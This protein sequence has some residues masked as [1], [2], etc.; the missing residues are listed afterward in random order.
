MKVG[1]WFAIIIL[2]L[3]FIIFL[4]HRNTSAIEAI[5]K[6]SARHDS[7]RHDSAR[8]KSASPRSAATT[9]AAHIAPAH[10]AAHVATKTKMTNSP[11][12]DVIMPTKVSHAMVHEA[13]PHLTYNQI[14]KTLSGV[15][16]FTNQK[17]V[18]TLTDIQKSPASKKTKENLNIVLEQFGGLLNFITMNA[19][20]I[21]GIDKT[22]IKESYVVE[23]ITMV[24]MILPQVQ[25]L[26]TELAT[27]TANFA[28][29][30][31][32]KPFV[33]NGQNINKLY[34]GLLDLAYKF[35]NFV[36]I[37]IVIANEGIPYQETNVI[38]YTY[39]GNK[40]IPFTTENYF[41][42]IRKSYRDLHMSKYFPDDGSMISMLSALTVLLNKI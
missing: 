12:V 9:S 28:L 19:S 27:T 20:D 13:E 41:S 31:S 25:V 16:K 10:V 7:A 11:M 42:S 34:Y 3:L 15:P 38:T 36:N 35:N 24:E 8:H 23:A 21:T 40:K 2:I 33:D 26:N 18:I 14:I 39:N 4:V 6:D 17:Q 37:Q 29:M 1:Y 22:K 30:L 5:V 32:G